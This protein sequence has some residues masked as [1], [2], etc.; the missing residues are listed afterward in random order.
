PEP[1]PG[2]GPVCE[3]CGT[4]PVGKQGW[5]RRCGWY[6]LLGRFVELD[7]WDREDLPQPEPQS[8]LDAFKALVPR[9]A[10]MLMAGFVGI[11]A[12]SVL[13]GLIL[14]AHGSARFVWT[15]GQ[16]VI[17]GVIVLGAHVACYVYSIMSN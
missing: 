14:P 7:P 11:I 6:P 3:K 5:C 15:V 16:M 13:I 2:I 17:G 9:W 10:W 12:S 4:P 8:K 1:P